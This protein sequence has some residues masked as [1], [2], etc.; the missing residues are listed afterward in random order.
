MASIVLS[1][2]A[3]DELVAKELISLLTRAGHVV[4]IA[5]H[6]EP[7]FRTRERAAY[8]MVVWSAAAVMSPDVY[9]DARMALKL[10]RLVQIVTGDLATAS[11]P[12]VFR[13]HPLI[14]NLDR[15]QI[16]RAV[17]EGREGQALVSIRGQF[18]APTP[19]DGP[20]PNMRRFP[21]EPSE[22]EAAAPGEEIG[23]PHVAMPGIKL[24]SGRSWPASGLAGAQRRTEQTLAARS[25]RVPVGDIRAR[26]VV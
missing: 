19:G 9:E 20:T 25:S 16:L 15:E 26:S 6:E 7:T 22:A 23:L 24:E 13:A 10:G 21:S 17:S 11:I 2:V 18:A 8:V 4:N 5:K 1:H 12:A 14:P 3:S